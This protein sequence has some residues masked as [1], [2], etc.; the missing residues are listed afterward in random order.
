MTMCRC[1]LIN[2][3]SHFSHIL[4]DNCSNYTM[5]TLQA[6]EEDSYF[7]FLPLAHVYDQIMETYCIYKGSSIGFWRGVILIS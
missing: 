4:H 3:L 7:S 6:T 2:V 1:S 5:V